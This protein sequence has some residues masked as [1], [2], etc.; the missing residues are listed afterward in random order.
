[1]ILLHYIQNYDMM[2][3]RYFLP[4]SDSIREAIEFRSTLLT[5]GER[6]LFAQLKT[7]LF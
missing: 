7:E 1:M 2:A 4:S 6:A 3:L 5:L